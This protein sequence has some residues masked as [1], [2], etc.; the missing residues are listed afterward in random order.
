MTQQD[1]RGQQM[2]RDEAMRAAM[3]RFFDDF[4]NMFSEHGAPLSL[5]GSM[6]L[7]P[8]L[9]CQRAMLQCYQKS[10]EERVSSE[11][12]EERMKQLTKVFMSSYLELI[13]CQRENREQFMR[14]QSDLI[15]NYLGVLDD[16]VHRIAAQKA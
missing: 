16:L 8:F 3:H 13:K 1:E 6:F 7:R 11:S 4:S 14:M 2:F 15:K 12:T 5:L 10:L 9:E